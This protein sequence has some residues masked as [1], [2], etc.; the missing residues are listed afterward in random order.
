[1]KQLVA[2]AVALGDD[3]V[4]EVVVVVVVVVEVV[5]MSVVAPDRCLISYLDVDDDQQ[6]RVC[7]LQPFSPLPISL[8]LCGCDAVKLARPGDEGRGIFKSVLVPLLSLPC[9]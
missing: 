3:V 4:G 8:S 2:V 5:A 1:M 7:L 6:S 9:L